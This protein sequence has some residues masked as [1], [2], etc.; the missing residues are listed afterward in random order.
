MSTLLKWLKKTAVEFADPDREERTNSQAQALHQEMSRSKGQFDLSATLEALGVLPADVQYVKDKMYMN[1]VTG[2]WKDGQLT[3]NE[4]NVLGW[5][6]MT[7]RLDPARAHQMRQSV[8]LTVF[9]QA[10]ASSLTDGAI[11]DRELQNLRTVASGLDSTVESLMQQF[12]VQEGEAFLR[13]LFVTAISDGELT[14]AEWQR[15]CDAV[16]KL[17]MT[18]QQFN[19]AIEQYARQ[20]VVHVLADAKADE[21]ISSEEEQQIEWLLQNFG[22]PAPFQQQVKAEIDELR[23]YEA[24]AAGRLPSIDRPRDVEIRSG[25]IIHW[26]SGATYRLTKNLKNGPVHQDSSGTVTL[27]DNRL[28]FTSPGASF[29]VGYRKILSHRLVGRAIEVRGESRSASRGADQFIFYEEERPAYAILRTAIGRANQTIVERSE[30]LPS[31]HIP[32][33]VRQRVWQRYGGRCAECSSDQYLEFDHIV[34]VAKG[35]NNFD[36]NVQLLCRKCNQNK[37]DFI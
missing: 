20:F 12:F 35:G 10:L 26:H 34:P 23:W 22:L 24:I 25:E 6:E 18:R 33:D 11:S 1:V 29:S 3:D 30:G 14:N 19:A 17:G 16:N 27:T 21:Q 36:T 8:G 9:R 31:R 32:R 37:S 2:G 5:V 13:N 15:I 7:L 4:K 28:I